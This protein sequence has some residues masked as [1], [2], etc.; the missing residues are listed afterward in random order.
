MKKFLLLS[1]FSFFTSVIVLS[2]STNV[3]T[4]WEYLET[5]KREKE[6]GNEAASIQALLDA[7]KE[8][9]PATKHPNT[10]Q[11]SKTW[12]RRGD[13]YYEIAV[14]KSP[15]L[16]LEKEGA[17]DTA[18]FSYLRAATVEKKDNGKQVI[19]DRG[20]VIFKLVTIANRKME[21]GNALLEDKLYDKAMLAYETARYAY[22]QTLLVDPKNPSLPS[23]SNSAL[24]A[25]VI[26]AVSADEKEKILSLGA[27]VVEKGAADAWV[28]QAM[29]G[30]Y[31]ENKDLSNAKDILAKGKAK[32]P[33]ESA[34]Y[35][36]ELRIA[37]EENNT[38]RATE[39]IK[40]GKEKF[41]DKKADF[42]L[43]EVNIY[44]TQGDDEKASQAL[45]EAIGAFQNEAEI[46]KVLYFNAGIIYD[47]LARK[48]EANKELA[49]INREKAHDYYNKTLELDSKYVSAY[50]QLANYH[51]TLGNEYL[52]EANNLPFEK[53]KEYDEMKA[54][55]LDEYKK[56]ASFL[57][58]GYAINK[59]KTIKNNLIEIYKKTQDYDKMKAL[60]NE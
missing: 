28:Y 47:N 5:Y 14:N 44:L 4:A 7:K 16:V 36:A 51:V 20:D 10:S 23:A 33:N 35:L 13:I 22:D 49:K 41:P 53:K 52:V 9:E 58:Q 56:A 21:Q 15:R 8:I 37:F 60:Q 48:N 38:V 59:D 2:Q 3:L 24:L 30:V 19:E 17:I 27:M 40:E 50:N 42:I 34:I 29:A 43:E 39:I 26:C 55:A 25:M 54:K 18:L 57:E 31:I 6:S 11:Q 12:K 32:F 46:L 45:E 1:V